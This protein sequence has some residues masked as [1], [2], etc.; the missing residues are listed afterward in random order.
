MGPGRKKQ[1]KI[2]QEPPIPTPTAICCDIIYL[3]VLSM[4]KNNIWVIG[5][6]WNQN[7]RGKANQPI[8]YVACCNC[9]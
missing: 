7:M 9:K 5:F 3:Y 8:Q 4:S 6:H 1:T 2:S